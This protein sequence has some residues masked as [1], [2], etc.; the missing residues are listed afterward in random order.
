VVLKT[1]RNDAT[2]RRRYDRDTFG[3]S[4]TI[5]ASPI[6]RAVARNIFLL[7][8]NRPNLQ[9]C[10]KNLHRHL[11]I[12]RIT[13]GLLLLLFVFSITP[14]QFL[15]DLIVQHKDDY[16]SISKGSLPALNKVGFQCDCNNQVVQMPYIVH[17]DFQLSHPALDHFTTYHSLTFGYTSADTRFSSLRGP[18]AKA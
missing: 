4:N 10:F 16:S 2:R 17:P 3:N 13:A 14:K 8:A 15:H 12:K 9:H 6:R 11:F 1:S 18:P 5:A 7:S